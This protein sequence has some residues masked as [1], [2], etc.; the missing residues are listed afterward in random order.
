M[1][2]LVDDQLLGVVLRGERLPHPVAPDATIYTTGYWYVRLCQAALG[3]AERAGV[4]SA[5][6][7]ALPPGR[8]EEALGAVLDLPDH[9]G[10]VSLRELGAVIA[11]LRSRHQLNILGSE[12]LAAAVHLEAAVALSAR[13]PKLEEALTAEGRPVELLP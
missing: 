3:A 13:S 10:L 2:V 4:L 11:R 1:I 12:A 8:R 9:I 7:Y 6:F 5:P